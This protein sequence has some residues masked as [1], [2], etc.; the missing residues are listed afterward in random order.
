MRG[1]DHPNPIRPFGRGD[2]K[3]GSA[4]HGQRFA[5]Q[6]WV[7]SE[8]DLA[9]IAP[10]NSI[11]DVLG[12]VSTGI[13]CRSDSVEDDDPVRIRLGIAEQAGMIVVVSAGK[14]NRCLG[15]AAPT[16]RVIQVHVNPSMGGPIWAIDFERDLHSLP[17]LG[18]A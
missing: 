9:D 18:V 17:W 11:M 12:E 15:V 6:P 1:G 4:R 8:N 10:W 13:P 5:L 14:V 2:E 3:P 7:I 16:V